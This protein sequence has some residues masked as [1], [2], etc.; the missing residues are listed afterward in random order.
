[1]GIDHVRQDGLERLTDTQQA[2]AEQLHEGAV[3][4]TE[5]IDA[6]TRIIEQS[7]NGNVNVVDNADGNHHH[8]RNH[9]VFYVRNCDDVIVADHDTNEVYLLKWKTFKKNQ[10]KGKELDARAFDKSER[11]QFNESDMKEWKSLSLIHI[12]EPTRPY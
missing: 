12:S 3:V 5:E 8:L 2:M 11:I 1:M 9:E 4:P 7:A 6:S 10:R